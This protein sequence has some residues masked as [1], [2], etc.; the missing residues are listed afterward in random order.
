MEAMGSK[1][2]STRPIAINR[3]GAGGDDGDINLMEAQQCARTVLETLRAEA[4]DECHSRQQNEYISSQRRAGI[5]EELPAYKK[6]SRIVDTAAYSIGL[7][8]GLATQEPTDQMF[9]RKMLDALA[10][11]SPVL[12]EGD[13]APAQALTARARDWLAPTENTDRFC[14]RRFFYF[15]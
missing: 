13:D 14:F 6:G 10:A 7:E 12:P 8:K 11:T 5:D 3:E 15:R 4:S 2:D 1:N 9:I